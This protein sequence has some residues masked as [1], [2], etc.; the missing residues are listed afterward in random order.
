MLFG[1]ILYF[2]YS[3]SGYYGHYCPLP[4][5]TQSFLVLVCTLLSLMFCCQFLHV[6]FRLWFVIPYDADCYT[7]S[8]YC[9]PLCTL[10]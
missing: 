2:E 6:P 1:C 3:D 9:W 7:P 8:L 4:G 5:F 10:P